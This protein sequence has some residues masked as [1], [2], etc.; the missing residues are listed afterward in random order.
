[1]ITM[2]LNLTLQNK[3]MNNNWI[4]KQNNMAES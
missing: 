1:M 4:E 2:D 3:P